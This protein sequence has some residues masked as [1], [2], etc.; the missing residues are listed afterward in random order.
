VRTAHRH[1]RDSITAAW[2]G[3]TLLELIIALSLCLLLMSA[4]YASLQLYWRLQSTGQEQVERAQIARAIL[5]RM[6]IDVG[7]VMF[8][9]P[10]AEQESDSDATGGSTVETA[11]DT[12]SSGSS[13]TG[14][15]DAT[16]EDTTIEVEDASSA[17]VSSSM[18]IVGDS[19]TL[20]LH[21]SRP[22]RD[23]TYA[24]LADVQ[25][26]RS[27]SSD[28]RS[29]SYFLASPGGAGLAGSV[30]PAAVV[31]RKASAYVAADS[32]LARL[33]GDRLAI[34][35]ADLSLDYEALGSAAQIVAPE[36][37]SLTFRYFDGT[38]WLESWDST[39]AGRLPQAIEVTLGIAWMAAPPPQGAVS[40]LTAE[41][42]PVETVRHVLHVPLAGPYVPEY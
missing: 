24:A 23:L 4:V 2:R 22:T 19:Q 18:G 33:E 28:I 36:V 12:G 8:M 5:R 25:D 20:V 14:E 16:E 29:V 3:F 26:L 17:Y 10:E 21:I 31:D 32:G 38:A 7:S 15:S 1:V 6:T 40:T 34:E 37:V 13:A 11:D 41:P 42:V 9:T 30:A 35:F 39:A 27:R